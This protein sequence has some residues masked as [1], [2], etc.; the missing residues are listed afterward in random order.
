MSVR[1][2]HFAMQVYT[3][4][5]DGG[6]TCL[7]GGQEVPKNQIR[8]EAFGTVDELNAFVGAARIS[9]AQDVPESQVRQLSYLQFIP[10]RLQVD[11]ISGLTLFAFRSIRFLLNTYV[12]SVEGVVPILYAISTYGFITSGPCM[13]S[14]RV[15]SHPA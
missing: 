12:V 5:G 7:V 1:K 6:T 4:K 13:A 2:H 9:I 10:L 11:A 15:E 3:K 14:W 8:I